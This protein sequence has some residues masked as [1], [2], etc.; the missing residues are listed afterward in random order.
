MV[1][2]IEDAS[3]T[4]YKNGWDGRTGGW[5]RLLCLKC[6]L[7]CLMWSMQTLSQ[8]N[9]ISSFRRDANTGLDIKASPVA[10]G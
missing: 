9:L 6:R 3:L 1:Q 10:P 5:L 2:F 8:E 7:S 4:S